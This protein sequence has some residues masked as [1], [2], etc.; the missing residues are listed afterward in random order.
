MDITQKNDLVINIC[1]NFALDVYQYLKNE[2]RY[3]MNWYSCYIDDMD[4]D[5]FQWARIQKVFEY[6]LWYES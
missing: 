4:Y 6:G 1:V 2:Y 5:I 3:Y